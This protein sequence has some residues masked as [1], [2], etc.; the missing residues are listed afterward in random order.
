[1]RIKSRLYD[2]IIKVLSQHK[3]WL[4][5][6]RKF[7][8]AWMVVGLIRSEKIGPTAWVPYVESRTQYAQSTQRRFTSMSFSVKAARQWFCKGRFDIS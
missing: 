1:M 5:A 2:T 8:L 6:R 3:K 4:D 7:T